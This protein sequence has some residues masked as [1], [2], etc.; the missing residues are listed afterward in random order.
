MSDMMNRPNETKSHFQQPT[1]TIG[2]S[3]V[4]PPVPLHFLARRE[5]AEIDQ[6]VG[7]LEQVHRTNELGLRRGNRVKMPQPGSPRVVWIEKDRKLRFRDC[8]T[9]GVL[10][11][12][13]ECH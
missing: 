5:L 11:R 12:R 8:D 9:F 6:L 7:H 1:P 13:G 3:N 2:P 10:V 4:L